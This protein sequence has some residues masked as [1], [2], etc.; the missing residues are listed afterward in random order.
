MIKN[1]G[2]TSAIVM[3]GGM[4]SACTQEAPSD[5]KKTSDTSSLEVQ[6][7]GLG[8]TLKSLEAGN[9]YQA[10]DEFGKSLKA[11]QDSSEKDVAD[12]NLDMNSEI[13]QLGKKIESLSPLD[14]A[15]SFDASLEVILDDSDSAQ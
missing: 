14:A 11:L 4:L 8:N 13:T 15:T 3:V 7:E 5:T 12:S 10:A 2:V 1:I 6:V 9:T